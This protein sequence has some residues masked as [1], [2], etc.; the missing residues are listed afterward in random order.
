MIEV[1]R[2]NVVKPNEAKILKAKLHQMYN[3]EAS[4]DLEDCD[5]ILRVKCHSADIKPEHIIE[6]LSQN[7]FFAEVLPDN[8]PQPIIQSILNAQLCW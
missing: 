8:Y 2:T 5:R 3:C 1:F 7:G 6:L 4:F